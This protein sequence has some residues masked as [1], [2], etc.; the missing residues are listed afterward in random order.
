LGY[1]RAI[2]LKRDAAKA[3][4]LMKHFEKNYYDTGNV[5]LVMSCYGAWLE[6]QEL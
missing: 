1:L 5:G 3:F 4:L 2:L 6:N